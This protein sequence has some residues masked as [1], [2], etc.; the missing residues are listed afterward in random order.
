M[1]STSS[2]SVYINIKELP[3][4]N[5]INNGDFLIVETPDGTNIIDYQDFFITLENTTFESTITNLQTDTQT[6]STNLSALTTS[7]NE[8]L[9]SLETKISPTFNITTVNVTLNSASNNQIFVS[10][11]SPTV[12]GAVTTDN[13]VIYT[14]P[15]GLPT[16]YY[17]RILRSKAGTVDIRPASGVTINGSTAGVTLG[18]NSVAEI[19][20]TGT[21]SYLVYGSI[22]TI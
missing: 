10:T 21:N 2:N 7:Y 9:S 6:L 8:L 20:W 19:Y 1:A 4:I 22:T 18:S 16:G 17:T 12:S 15:A 5:D 13:K 11:N 14:I 3:V